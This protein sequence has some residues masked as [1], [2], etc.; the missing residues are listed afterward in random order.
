MYIYIYIYVYIYIYFRILA[1][2]VLQAD[3]RYK[4]LHEAY[5]KQIQ[6]MDEASNNEGKKI[7]EINNLNENRL[8]RW[9]SN[10][11]NKCIAINVQYCCFYLKQEFAYQYSQ[12]SSLKQTDNIDKIFQEKE[13]FGKYLKGKC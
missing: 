8:N 5:A 11:L 13:N 9:Y 10:W 2:F 1:V 6:L 12:H 3:Q 4:L 7:L